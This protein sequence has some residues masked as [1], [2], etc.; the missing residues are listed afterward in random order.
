MPSSLIMIRS[1]SIN[2]VQST[3]LAPPILGISLNR[4][5][6]PFTV[7]FIST[8]SSFYYSQLII[9]AYKTGPYTLGP[10][11]KSPL[12]QMQPS[13]GLS[14]GLT[15]NTPNGTGWTVETQAG[16]IDSHVSADYSL[17]I[18]GVKI[19]VG[20][21][22]GTMGGINGFVDTEGRV[23]KLIRMGWLVQVDLKGGVIGKLRQVITILG[24][25]ND[26]PLLSFT[27][28]HTF[29]SETITPSC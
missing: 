13:S 4:K 2:A 26:Y 6:Y 9:P 14:L 8:L 23:S 25:R 29:T 11:G 22:W 20:S 28:A 27:L 12:I 17:R 21:S 3:I 24:P 1:V 5:L 19:K 16:I 7:G 10:W 15:S 18:A